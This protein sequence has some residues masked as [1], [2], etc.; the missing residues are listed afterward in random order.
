MLNPSVDFVKP[1]TLRQLLH[2]PNVS[3]LECAQCIY[4]KERVS[5]T[6]EDLEAFA[7]NHTLIS[8]ERPV[9]GESQ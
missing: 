3:L 8:E 5:S 1:G 9:K 6:S 2:P 7:G 4:S